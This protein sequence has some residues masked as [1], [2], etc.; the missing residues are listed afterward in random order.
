[1]ET[2]NINYKIINT[3]IDWNNYDNSQVSMSHIQYDFTNISERM[4]L[5]KE[6]TNEDNIQVQNVLCGMYYNPITNNNLI[7][8]RHIPTKGFRTVGQLRVK[9]WTVGSGYIEDACLNGVTLPG[10][11]PVNY[12]LT[13]YK[14]IIE[15]PPVAP[16]LPTDYTNHLTAGVSL[17]GALVL[18]VLFKGIVNLFTR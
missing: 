5:L 4:D 8:D 16:S 7:Q 6:Y 12:K 11:N 15:V 9:Q 17:L 10:E 18:V 1:M 13:E 14:E 3:W 2:V